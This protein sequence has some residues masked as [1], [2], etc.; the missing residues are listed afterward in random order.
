[1]KINNIR[2]LPCSI[3]QKMGPNIA[4]FDLVVVRDSFGSNRMCHFFVET[5]CLGHNNLDNETILWGHHARFFR[6][7]V[8]KLLFSTLLSME[9]IRKW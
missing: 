1:M 4:I 6:Q 5:Y 3:F 9:S 7:W 2:G 8:P